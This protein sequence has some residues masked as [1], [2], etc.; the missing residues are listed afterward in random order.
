LSGQRHDADWPF[1][2]D[3]IGTP[4]TADKRLA[5]RQHASS[6]KSNQD[7]PGAAGMILVE[8]AL[9]WL[10]LSVLSV[11]VTVALG[12]A[13]ARGDSQPHARTQVQLDSGDGIAHA[14]PVE[15]HRA[16]RLLAG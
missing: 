2:N 3:T 6:G 16:A 12:R 8:I 14:A 13:A 10:V 15:L 11:V 4:R 1:S 5:M 9:T 7:N